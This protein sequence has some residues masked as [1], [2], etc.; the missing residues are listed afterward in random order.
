MKSA[1][2]R[3]GNFASS[4]AHKMGPSGKSTRPIIDRGNE[5]G[6]RFGKRRSLSSLIHRCKNF[7][8]RSEERAH[9]IAA[10]DGMELHKRG[11]V[12]GQGAAHANGNNVVLGAMKDFNARRGRAPG[13]FAQTT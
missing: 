13:Q 3:F 5:G 2:K 4:V 11:E 9:V 10:F 7:G 12:F 8:R 1:R 6:G